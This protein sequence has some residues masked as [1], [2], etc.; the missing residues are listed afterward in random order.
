MSGV[1]GP[2][3]AR[4]S[5]TSVAQ[6]LEL[7]FDLV[8]V[9]A[10]AVITDGLLEDQTVGGFGLAALGYVA[11][12]L[13]WVAVVLYANVAEGAVHTRTVVTSMFLLALMAATSPGAEGGHPNLFAIGFLLVRFVAARG[14]LHTG[15]VLTSWPLLQLGGVSALWIAAMW[16][17][18]PAKY[19]LWTI[20]LLLEIGG[21]FL[22]RTAGQDSVDRLEQ[23][24]RRK[25][26]EAVHRHGDR[27][28]DVP[29]HFEVA[30]VDTAHLDERLGLF[31]IIVL[32]EV[33][34]Q[35]VVAASRTPW[36]EAFRGAIVA[37]FGT[38]VAL[39][40]LTFSHGYTAAP[41]TRFATLPP[42]YGLPMHLLSTFGIVML[43]AGFG[44]T[45]NHPDDPLGTLLR[46]VMCGG[47]ALHMAVSGISGLTAGAPPR[48]LAGWAL[49]CAVAPLVVA[50]VGGHLANPG[51]VWLLFAV[52][53]WQV[54]YGAV[55]R[56]RS[57]PVTAAPA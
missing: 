53:M 43:A 57:D 21:V 20:G 44:W 7:F 29:V 11:V 13:S 12:W 50:A 15:K 34:T 32:G 48:W 25:H 36:D 52:V 38:L 6:W 47:L 51:I 46:W 56:R 31:L 30:E 22:G 49:P 40:W 10:V 17:Q 24:M 23:Q 27:A 28:R 9:A 26:D 2:P 45:A 39:W 33:V 8:V 14:S 5:E 41:H 18:T 1:V 55:D 3:V 4:G 54:A 42:R 35:L 19:W 16:V 37:S